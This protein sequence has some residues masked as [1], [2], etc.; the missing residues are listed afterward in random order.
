MPAQPGASP[1]QEPTWVPDPHDDSFEAGAQRLTIEAYAE[2]QR[3]RQEQPVATL[4]RGGTPPDF[5]TEHGTRTHTWI[6]GPG[7]GGSVVVRVRRFHVLDAIE[8]EVDQANTED[9][10]YD[11]LLRHAPTVA[12]R[13]DAILLARGARRFRL[14]SRRR[15]PAPWDQPV[16]PADFDPGAAARLK[17]IEDA[18]RRRAQQVPGLAGSRLVSQ[19]RRRGGCRIEPIEPIN[20]DPTSILYCAL[21]TGSPHSYRITIEPTGAGP[22]RPGA[23]VPRWAE[24]DALRGDTWYECKC[25]YEALLNGAARG[26][27]AARAVLDKLTRQVLNH[28]DIAQTCG[29]T[30]RYIVSSNWVRDRLQ[31]EWFGNVVIDV[32]ESEWC[33]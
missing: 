28:R 25:G 7:G 15:V 19:G 12:L 33:N 21:A 13:E 11:T 17:V 26:D 1:Y 20:N 27:G 8:Y 5:V 14:P 23:G 18:A 3:M 16:Y 30:Y 6:G 32:V 2:R 31:A 9:D 4:N 24:I 29:L 10:L 22:E